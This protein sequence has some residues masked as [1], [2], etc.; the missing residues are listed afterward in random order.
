ML[1]SYLR[2]HPQACVHGELYGTSGPLTFF[3]VDYKL[4]PPLEDVLRGR[5]DADPVSFLTD[6]A[7]VAGDRRA[8]GFKFKYEELLLP[9]WDDVRDHLIGDTSIAIVHLRRANLFDRYLS[10]HLAVR[11]NKMYNTQQVENLPGPVSVHLRIEDC[12]ASFSET[13]L[14]EQR[15]RGIFGE[16]LVFE[17]TYEE[18]IDDRSAATLGRLQA[19]LGLD[20]AD[21]RATTLKLQ[22]QERHDVVEN[23]D[24]L[25]EYFAGSVYADCFP[26][27]QRSQ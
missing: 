6:F 5:R 22:R 12:E 27:A 10:E 8:V 19:F 7:L 4:R 26:E 13:R 18:L 21:L 1:I 25:I 24:E 20:Q 17:V 3:G 14:R 9:L 2:S 15:L 11:V 16:H 23:Y